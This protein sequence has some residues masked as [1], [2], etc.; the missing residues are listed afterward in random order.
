[1]AIDSTPLE[2]AGYTGCRG[3]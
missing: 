3:T 1:V 2:N